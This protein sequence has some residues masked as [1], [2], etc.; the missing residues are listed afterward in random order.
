MG[1]MGQSHDFCT[2][3]AY[4]TYEEAYGTATC[5]SLLWSGGLA[6]LLLAKYMANPSW[7]RICLRHVRKK[8]V[9]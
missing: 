6:L 7:H 5:A 1:Q 2:Q 4:L 9:P 3:G 8:E